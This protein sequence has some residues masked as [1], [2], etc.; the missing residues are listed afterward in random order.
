MLPF[1]TIFDRSAS[2]GVGAD[3]SGTAAPVADV[4]PAY[5]WPTTGSALGFAGAPEGPPDPGL[6]TLLDPDE[7][8]RIGGPSRLLPEE[9]PTGQGPDPEGQHGDPGHRADPRPASPPL[10]ACGRLRLVRLGKL[11]EVVFEDL[12]EPDLR[13]HHSTSAAIESAFFLQD[14]RQAPQPSAHPLAGRRLFAVQAVGD[15]R[16]RERI[17]HAQ[18]QRFTLILREGGERLGE[19]GAERREVHQ[20]FDPFVVLQWQVGRRQPDLLPS[21]RVH[22][23][24]AEEASQLMP[25]DPVQ[26]RHPVRSR[27]PV[28]P[29]G[30]ERL[31]E[32]LRR[33][34]G[35][36]LGVERPPGEVAQ[37]VLGVPPIDLHERRGIRP[38]REE[39][40]RIGPLVHPNSDV[41]RTRSGSSFAA[42]CLGAP[43]V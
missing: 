8:R 29:P 36:R 11:E 20:V 17:D 31:G 40:L 21:G 14:E 7:G 34:L 43:W 25:C 23:P 15:L 9:A 28:V 26:P 1:R 6:G 42:S 39:Q 38:R 19:G 10:R 24:R 2:G 4:A 33:Q 3:T 16:I 18:P 27:V 30:R 37:Q 22:A 12:Q 41:V 5:W 32:G 13:V 35:R